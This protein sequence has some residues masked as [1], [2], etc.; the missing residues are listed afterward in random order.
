M[1]FDRFQVEYKLFINRRLCIIMVVVHLGPQMGRHVMNVCG[2]C[3][4][5]F[6]FLFVIRDGDGCVSAVGTDIFHMQ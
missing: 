6:L 4:R 3:Y 2:K 5:I 1:N